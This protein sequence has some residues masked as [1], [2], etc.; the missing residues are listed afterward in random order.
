M[1]PET[2]IGK[3][4]HAWKYRGKGESFE[5]FSNRLAAALQDSPEHFRQFRH[6]IRNQKFLPGGRIQSA[7]GSSRQSTPYNCFVMDTIRD[8]SE[9]ILD[10]HRDAY[11]TMRLGGGVGYDFSNL[12]PAGDRIRTLDALASGPVSF[13]EMFDSTCKTV[14]SA[15]HRR[16]AQM[17]VL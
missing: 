3:Y 9:S 15:G 7:M 12:R 10:V 16:G 13:M 14:A 17:G 2:E 4:I 8:D 11:K 5:E 6:I 1:G